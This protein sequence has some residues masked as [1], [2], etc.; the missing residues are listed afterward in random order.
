LKLERH[1]KF[2]KNYDDL[3]IW[4]FAIEG[5]KYQKKYLQ[6]EE[7]IPQVVVNDPIKV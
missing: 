6:R 5:V 7:K 3:I 1:K 4:E 2:I